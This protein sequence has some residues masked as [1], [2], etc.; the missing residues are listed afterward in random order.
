[1]RG[2]VAVD[3]R[4]EHETLASHFMMARSL[5]FRQSAEQQSSV[6]VSSLTPKSLLGDK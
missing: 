5:S 1:V 2:D 4:D 6:E 3:A